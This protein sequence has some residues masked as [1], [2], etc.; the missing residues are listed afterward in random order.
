MSRSFLGSVDRS[1][2]N[3]ALSTIL[4]GFFKDACQVRVL[5]LQSGLVSMSLAPV[6]FVDGPDYRSVGEVGLVKRLVDPTVGEERAD[7]A[8]PNEHAPVELLQDA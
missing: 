4:F 1:S 8:V 6:L 3:R 5:K 2:G 7:G